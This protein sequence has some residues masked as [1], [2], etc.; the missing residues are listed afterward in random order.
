MGKQSQTLAD[1]LASLP[2]EER[3][4]LTM[5]YLKSMSA[6]EIATILGVPERSAD[7]IIKQGKSRL[8]AILGI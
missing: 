5:H 1:V 8:S 4:I 6:S 2:D 3:I 7:A